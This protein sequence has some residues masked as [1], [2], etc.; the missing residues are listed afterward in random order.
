MNMEENF[1]WNLAS[2]AQLKEECERLEKE[3]GEKQ[4]ELG[5][6]VSKIDEFNE[7]L[8][9]MSKKYRELKEILNK[10]EGKNESK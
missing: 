9:N 7:I 2:N 1:N 8:F 6:L 3:F 4:K 5:G 10:R